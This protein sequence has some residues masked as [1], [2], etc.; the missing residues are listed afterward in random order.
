LSLIDCRVKPGNDSGGV[1]MRLRSTSGSA[2]RKLSAVIVF[3]SLALPAV[4]MDLNAYRAGHGKPAL[5]YSARLAGIA[6]EQARLMAGRGRIDHKDFLKRIGG[7]GCSNRAG[8][9]CAVG[10]TH[11]ENVS[12]GCA[13][14]DC[15]INRWAKSP[16]HRANMLRGDVSAY[17]LGSAISDKGRK[18]WA[19][20]L[21][22]E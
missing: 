6:Y 3:A 22:G 17:G 15:V 7:S 19:L 10:S 2:C 20:E 9:T 4:A 5:S 12:Y 11:A 8:A 13:D 18:Y 21:G 16:G 1:I 14:E